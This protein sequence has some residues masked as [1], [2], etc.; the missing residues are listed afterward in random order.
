MTR[1]EVQLQSGMYEKFN[2]AYNDIPKLVNFLKDLE[3]D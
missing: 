2:I 1:I 3:V